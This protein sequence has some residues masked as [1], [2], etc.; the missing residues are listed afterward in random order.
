MNA[1]EQR[2]LDD[3]EKYVL[4]ILNVSTEGDFPPFFYSIGIEK[5]LGMPELI[6]IGLK[7]EVAQS[8]INECYRQMKSGT[9]GPGTTGPG[10]PFRHG[11]DYL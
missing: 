6:V 4:H 10:L 8:A 1:G 9:T 11:L 3:I 7:P 2:A 5:S